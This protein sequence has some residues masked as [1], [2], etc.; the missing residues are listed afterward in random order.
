MEEKGLIQAG[1]PWFKRIK[2]YRVAKGLT[3]QE[4]ARR[5]GVQH[6]RYWSWEAG[7]N[8]PRTDHQL[9]LAEVLGVEHEAIFGGTTQDFAG[10]TRKE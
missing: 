7:T 2:L 1:T 5:V 4:V 8:V 6:R 9:K 10:I 3:Q